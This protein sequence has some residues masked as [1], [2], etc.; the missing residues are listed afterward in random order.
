[1]TAQNKETYLE[2]MNEEYKQK[3]YP[4]GSVFKAH[5]KAMKGV[6]AGLGLFFMGA[7]L[8]GSIAGLVWSINRTLEIIRDKEENMLGVG[9]GISV[10]FLL[11]VAV[12]GVAVFF[13]TKDI[14]KTVDDWIRVAAKVG[15]LEE[16]EI[17]EFDKQAMGSDS[18]ILNHLGK[19]KSFTT[20]Q[21][22]G[23]LTRDYI[24]LYGGNMPCVLKLSRLTQAYIKDNTYYVKVGKTRKQTHYLTIHLMTED[25]KTAWAE[26]SREA[27]RALQDELESRCPGIDTAGGSVLPG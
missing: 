26:T 27:A 3:H 6:N 2:S 10:F 17:R 18:L 13:I 16:Q 23:I 19:L 7:F 20:G 14:R 9:I 25:K 15:G 1:M 8:A 5:K 12:F 21:K 4:E 11:L 24:C 22:R